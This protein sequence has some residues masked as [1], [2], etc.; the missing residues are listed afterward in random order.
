METV[1]STSCNMF[2]PSHVYHEICIVFAILL[3]GML[4]YRSIHHRVD[5]KSLRLYRKYYSRLAQWYV[6]G[7]SKRLKIK[8]MLM[9]T[10]VDY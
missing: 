5:A 1:P 9:C 7:R 6:L 3:P 2:K 10:A 8:S 4:Q